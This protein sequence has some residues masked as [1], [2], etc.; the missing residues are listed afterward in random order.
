MCLYV[1]GDFVRSGCEAG[2]QGAITANVTHV[3]TRRSLTAVRQT[4]GFAT[5]S[6]SKR[7]GF[8]AV[9]EHELAL[10]QQNST[11]TSKPRHPMASRVN[12][13]SVVLA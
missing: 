13:V 8:P 4:N 11:T 1:C 12:N 3:I 10:R 2:A 5:N 9:H 6:M 7:S